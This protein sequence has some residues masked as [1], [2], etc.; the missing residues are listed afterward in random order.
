MFIAR[1]YHVENL[2]AFRSHIF[3]IRKM[4]GCLVLIVSERNRL[5]ENV[6]GTLLN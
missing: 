6:K 4:N 5:T 1:L 3:R 2:K